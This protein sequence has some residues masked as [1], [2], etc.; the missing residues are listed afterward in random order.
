MV[1]VTDFTTSG[2]TAVSATASASPRTDSANN[3]IASRRSCLFIRRCHSTDIRANTEDSGDERTGGSDRV[4]RR[5]L[6]HQRLAR[7]RELDRHPRGDARG[8]P[9]SRCAPRGGRQHP[10][11]AVLR[12]RGGR[13]RGRRRASSGRRDGH[14]DR[15]RAHGRSGVE[16][17]HVAARLAVVVGPRACGRPVWRRHSRRWARRHQLGSVQRVEARGRGRHLARARHRARRRLRDRLVG[18]PHLAPRLASRG[19]TKYADR[20]GRRSGPRRG[21]LPSGT[22]RTT[23]RRQWASSPRCSWPT[24]ASRR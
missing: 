18:R 4:G 10:R 5:V 20:C 1:E 8:A 22:A 19:P 3:S 24:A 6:L 21:S 13:R 23:A 15:R 7:R 14:G 12:C 17:G 9:R 16:P 2:S 11:S